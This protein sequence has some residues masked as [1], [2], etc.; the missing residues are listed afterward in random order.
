MWKKAALLLIIL[1]VA[2]NLAFIGVWA[3]HVLRTRWHAGS[4]CGHAEGGG[5][6]WCPLHRQLGASTEQWKRIEPRLSEFREAAQA[7]CQDVTR[8]RSEMID[9]LASPQPDRQ[10]IAA[11]QEEILTGQRKMQQLVTDHLLAEKDVL[12]PE[13]QKEL[14]DLL[15]RR[16]GCIGMGPMSGLM[17][18]GGGLPHADAGRCWQ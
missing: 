6:I 10:A 2:L 14:F 13:Q 3:T 12:T 7:V 16:S 9:L 11:K 5:G 17:D 15:R 18:E 1:S 8:R 4:P